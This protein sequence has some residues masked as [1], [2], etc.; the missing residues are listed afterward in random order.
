MFPMPISIGIL[1]AVFGSIAILALRRPLLA[2]LALREA[3]RRRGQSAVF[4]LGMMFGTAAILAMEGVTDSWDHLGKVATYYAW[5]RTDIT[6]S[7]GGQLFSA[8]VARDLSIAPSVVRQAAGVEGA[9]ELVGSVADGDKRLS[10]SP[11]QIDTFDQ[12][13][14]RFATPVLSDGKT[15]DLRSLGTSDAIL[16]SYL[17]SR[18]NARTGDSIQIDFV[19]GNRQVH[20]VQRVAGITQV[21]LTGLLSSQ[22]YIPLDAVQSALGTDSVN[23]VRISAPGDGQQEVDNAAALAPAV[24]SAVTTLPS[25]TGLEVLEVK[26]RD[27]TASANAHNSFRIFLLTLSL[28]VALA[29]T[30]LVVNLALALAEERRPR[31]AVLRALGL[32]RSG[33]IA[34]ALIEGAA[35]SLTAAVIGTIPGAIYT[36]YVDSR[37]IPGLPTNLFLAGD[38]FFAITPS[39]IAFSI[40]IGALITL[41]TILVVSIRTSRMS[42]SSAVRDMPEPSAGKRGSRIQVAFAVVLGLAGAGAWLPG[43]PTLRL[44]G[45][46]AL[47]VAASML[48]RRVLAQRLHATLTGAAVTLWAFLYTAALPLQSIGLG[49]GA[50]LTFVMVTVAVFGAAVVISANL[51]LLEAPVR[52]IS[53]RLVAT[54]RPPLAYLTRRPVRAGFATGAFALVLAAL[55]FFTVAWASLGQPT[56]QQLSG[57]YDVAVTTLGAESLTI[58][59]SL[60]G[61]VARSESIRTLEYVGPMSQQN[62]GEDPQAWQSNYMPLYPLTEDQLTHPPLPL[63]SRDPRY[64]TDIAVWNAVR[65]DPTLAIGTFGNNLAAVTLV[66]SQG[67]VRIKIVGVITGVM[68]ANPESGASAGLIGSGR[69]FADVT[70]TGVGATVLI[71]TTPGV[72]ARAFAQEVRQTTFGQGVDAVATKELGDL[73][74]QQ[75]VWYFSF[76]TL[77]L[78]TGVVVGVLSLGILA[79]R[80]AIDRRRAIGVLRAL[81][82]RPAQILAG[83]LIEATVTSTVGVAVGLGIGLAAGFAFQSESGAQQAPLYWG[84]ILAPAIAIFIAVWLVTIGPAVRT[85]RLPTTEA[86]RIIG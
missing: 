84:M 30:A 33:L 17:A 34:V 43:D 9:F 24:R 20:V 46:S 25:A 61:R 5:G 8:Q 36:Y 57:G 80:S 41:L 40:C 71:R 31:L 54:I 47:I 75:G 73:Y 83:V 81:G 26:A 1:V 63:F 10:E 52:L 12:S 85:S 19:A 11:V 60:S 44:L 21:A 66:G 2:R 32:T 14:P 50:A 35:Y 39:S 18:L 13:V 42:I 77:L 53:G 64:A 3:L 74:F 65:N 59:D 38:S 7:Q 86:L 22:I 69:T 23:M 82:Y 70:P 4:V 37:P 27:L 49:T 56:D 78:Q 51:R 58:P 28:F 55:S 79:L 67:K 6:V 68:L 72:D 76:F 16:S 15:A 48:A 29:A 62:Q 45:G